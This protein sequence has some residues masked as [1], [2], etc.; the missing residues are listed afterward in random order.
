MK[1]NVCTILLI[2]AVLSL[3]AYVSAG[4]VYTE[5]IDMSFLMTQ[6]YTYTGGTSGQFS[7]NNTTINFQRKLHA[8]GQV[9]DLTGTFTFN[10]ALGRDFS[11][12]GLARGYFDGNATVT[13]VGGLKLNSNWVYGGT[14]IAAKTIFKATLLPVY[15]DSQNPSLLRWSLTE[16]P[17]L[18]GNFNRTLLLELVAG[19]E[20]LA[21]GI[22]LGNGNILTMSNQALKMDLS[23]KSSVNPNDFISTNLNSGSVAAPVRITA[24]PEPTTLLLLALG[25][26]L[27]KKRYV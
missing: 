13:I 21:S 6:W 22:D 4:M 14:G 9:Y 7:F 2:A 23:M 8:G 20:G 3:P 16:D 11:S 15:E 24:V 18:I 26:V 27:L 5:L 25:S 12:G 17:D 19:S 1:K 10:P